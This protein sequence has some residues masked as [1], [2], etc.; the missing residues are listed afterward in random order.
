MKQIYFGDGFNSITRGILSYTTAM[1]HNLVPKLTLKT[2]YKVLV[3]PHSRRSVSFKELRPKLQFKVQ[4]KLGKIHLYKFS[5]GRKCILI[6][7]GWGDTSGSFYYLIKFLIDQGYS[8]WSFDHIGHGQSE[9]NISHLFGFIEGFKSVL[10]QLDKWDLNVYGIVAHSMGAAAL[11]NLDK[12][13]LIDKKL[14]LLSTPIKFF[15]SMFTKM[16]QAGISKRILKSLLEDVSSQYGR[17]WKELHPFMHYDKVSALA[18]LDNT[19]FIHDKD[20][21]D[22]SYEDLADYVARTNMPLMTTKELGHRKLL[23]DNTVFEMIRLKLREDELA[24]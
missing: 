15:E 21:H 8:V 20:D 1:A 12:H 11:L 10:D 4:T 23:R 6:S 24:Q 3:N 22:C 16:D 17:S 5:E 9:G 19:L 13:Y 2:S 18:K 14:F 7:H